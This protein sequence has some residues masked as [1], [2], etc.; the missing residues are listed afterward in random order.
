[1]FV[2]NMYHYTTNNDYTWYNICSARFLDIRISTCF[3][4]DTCPNPFGS[5]FDPVINI[6]IIEFIIILFAGTCKCGF[7]K[8]LKVRETVKE[9]LSYGM[10]PALY[11]YLFQK[12]DT[13]LQ[14]KEKVWSTSCV[15]I[16]FVNVL[17]YYG[18]RSRL[19]INKQHS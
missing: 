10:S 6:C 17:C 13:M 11:P 16:N 9:V 8:L 15:I 19:L 14:P 3:C 18:Y 2:F 5:M 12:I 4:S 7:I 1:M